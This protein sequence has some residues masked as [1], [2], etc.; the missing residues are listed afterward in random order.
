MPQMVW[1][2]RADG[3]HEYFNRRW[4]EYT[5]S[6]PEESLGE[7]WI[8]QL[9]PVDH[10]QIRQRWRHS[11]R[12]GE[13]Y[14]IEYRIRQA[15]DG[16]YHWHLGRAL[17][18]Q[19]ESGR[20][21]QWFGT[22]TDI[23]DQ[24]RARD[25]SRFIAEASAILSG[26]LDYEFTLPAVAR[27]AIPQLADWCAIDLAG[28]NGAI[29][30]IVLHHRDPAR[31]TLAQDISERYQHRFAKSELY[32]D[33]LR[34]GK[35]KLFSVIA[36]ELIDAVAADADHARLIRALGLRSLIWVPMTVGGITLGAIALATAETIRH[37]DS[38]DLLIAEDL[39]GRAALALD[40]ARLYR[41]ARESQHQLKRYSEELEHR[42]LER[43]AELRDIN[44][45]LQSS[46]RELQDF[47]SVASHDL[48]EPLR[49]IQAFGDRLTARATELG[50]EGADYLRRMKSAAVR[51][52]TLISDL[53]EFSRITTKAQP[54]ISV[55]LRQVAA[56]V[57]ADLEAAVERSGG[58]VEIGEMPRIDA[59]PTQMRQLLQNLIC[60][61][62]KF[63]KPDIAPLVRVHARLLAPDS[64]AS[65][66]P[67]PG[68]SSAVEQC[69]IVVEDNG[70]G[71]DEKYLDR[72]F[73]VF[74]RL[75]GRNTYEGTGIGLAVCRKIAERHGGSITAR[76]HP[77]VGSTF[78][79]TLIAHRDDPAP[80]QAPNHSLEECNAD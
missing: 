57:L 79:V 9:D 2:A 11:L 58:R 29:R 73:N 70:I 12:T 39:A 50:P 13:P 74:Q 53:L 48:Q 40:N 35:S 36:P 20:I 42:V 63:R 71:F 68:G 78:I 51:M 1:V 72:I 17:P 30:R 25:S 31:L 76:S 6:T 49:K 45:R 66:G 67:S 16:S 23:H 69:E 60:N 80:D 62:L 5:G 14:E 4:Y 46:N 7:G 56:E 3:Y 24:K 44:A 8:S 32:A 47:A 64:G 54:F 28:A 55:D 77:E 38:A 27:L 21:V 75:H 22:C 37:Y 65:A 33:V 43:T 26:S 41:E 10:E 15:S 18:Q 59:D 61:A 19:D 52:Q 34:H